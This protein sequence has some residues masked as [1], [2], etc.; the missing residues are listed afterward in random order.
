M[1]AGFLD[2]SASSKALLLELNEHAH[3]SMQGWQSNLCYGGTEA[4]LAQ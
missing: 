2:I 4:C 1:L 3:P